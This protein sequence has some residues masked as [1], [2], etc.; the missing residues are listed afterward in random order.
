MENGDKKAATEIQ[1]INENSN[2]YEIF[3]IRMDV[4]KGNK[5]SRFDMNE[6]KNKV[7]KSG[8]KVK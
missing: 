1:E 4:M 8:T 7:V 6:T 3:E 2:R 5:N